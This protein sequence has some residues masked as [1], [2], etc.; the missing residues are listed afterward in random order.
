MSR[1]HPTVRVGV[2][3]LALLPLGCG[4]KG[5][6]PKTPDELGRLLADPNPEV[7]REAA[8]GLEQLGAKA[9]GQSSAL[10]EALRTGKEPR[11]R[12]LVATT[13]GKIGP[14][15]KEAIPALTI[16]VGDPSYD[17]QQA[18]AEALGLMGPDAKSAVPALE[19]MSKGYDPC[20]AANEALKKIR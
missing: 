3:V 10:I 6:P 8:L 19:K 13:L 1:P 7:Q 15:A 16:A 5:P 4:S 11:V 17:V 2:I 18:A 9:Q 20:K 14:A 12:Q